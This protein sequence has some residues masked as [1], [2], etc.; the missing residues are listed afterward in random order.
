MFNKILYPTD[1][2]PYS[3][4]VCES[5]AKLKPAGVDS[6]IVLNVIDQRIFT[7]FPEVSVDVINAMKESSQTHVAEL[8]T[9]L[10]QLGIP[11][12]TRVEM[13]IPF[14]QIV[15]VAAAE[16][17]SLIVIGS[18]GKS[19]IEEMLLGSTT[20]NV[21][22][23]ATVPL[24][25]E[26]YRTTRQGNEI[27][28]SSA[29][30]NPFEKILYPTDFSACANS[31]IPYLK[32]MKAAGT[33]EIVVVHIQDMTKIAP[34]LLDRLPEFDDIDT[35]RL[36]NIKADLLAAGIERVKIVLREGVPF[37]EINDLA[38]AEDVGL[39]ALGSHGKSMV[40]EMLLGSVSGKVVRR[41]SRPILLIKR[42]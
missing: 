6:V 34:H 16:G 29:H 19:L 22:R 26:K 10:E 1:F 41:S 36:G 39:V 13:G 27:L 3:L 24:L 25:I 5:I 11:A 42:K 8:K 9:K 33:K 28:C 31:V 20:E 4:K 18:H 40:K 7:Q 15:G 37:R 30:E 32:M 23:H 21:L 17:V 14:H 2:S 12:T 35:A 38:Q